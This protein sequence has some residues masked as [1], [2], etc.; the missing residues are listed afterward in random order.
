[1]RTSLAKLS[2]A[3]AEKCFCSQAWVAQQAGSQGEGASWSV[4]KLAAGL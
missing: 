3:E 4:R 2:S 1:V